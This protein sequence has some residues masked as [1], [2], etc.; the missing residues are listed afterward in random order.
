[1]SKL[2]HITVN[3]LSKLFKLHEKEINLINFTFDIFINFKLVIDIKFLF[4]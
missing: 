3:I 2:I 4:F 1:M